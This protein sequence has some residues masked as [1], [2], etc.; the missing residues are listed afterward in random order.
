MA[1]A[2]PLKYVVRPGGDPPAFFLLV[3]EGF[4]ERICSRAT[5]LTLAAVQ[6]EQQMPGMAVQPVV[7]GLD[8]DA[9]LRSAALQPTGNLL[10]RVVAL[11]LAGHQC[12]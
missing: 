10:W 2:E 7:D 11:Q 1:K 4:P 5:V 6:V 3:P 8:G 12:G 9:E